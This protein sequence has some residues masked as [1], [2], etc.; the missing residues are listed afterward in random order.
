VESDKVGF[1]FF[2]INLNNLLLLLLLL[3]GFLEAQQQTRPDNQLAPP[4]QA[5]WDRV[6][7]NLT[8]TPLG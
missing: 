1:F 3:L 8:C 5:H 7:G 4:S 6:S 2:L